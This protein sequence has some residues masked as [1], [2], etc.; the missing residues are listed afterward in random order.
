M[1]GVCGSLAEQLARPEIHE[2]SHK[3]S[4]A[5]ASCKKLFKEKGGFFFFLKTT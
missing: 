2:D 5:A 3:G 1:V 4:F